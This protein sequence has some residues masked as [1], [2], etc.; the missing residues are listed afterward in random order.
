[1][2]LVAAAG[3]LL[4]AFGENHTPDARAAASIY[5]RRDVFELRACSAIANKTRDVDRALPR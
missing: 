5:R 1:M 2:S 4:T 3:I